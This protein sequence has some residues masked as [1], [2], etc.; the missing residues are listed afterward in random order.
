RHG[1]YNDLS[2]ASLKFFKHHLKYPEQIEK[3]LLKFENELI[4][5]YNDPDK[6]QKLDYFNFL[7]WI[8]N[9]RSRVRS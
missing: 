1:S 9:K 4:D 6:N 2:R 8:Q 7:E 5:I 3:S